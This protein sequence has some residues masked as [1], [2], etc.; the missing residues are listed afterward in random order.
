MEVDLRNCEQT[1]G[2]SSIIDFTDLKVVK[3]NRTRGISGKAIY[4]VP[5]DESFLGESIIAIKQ[6]GEYRLLPF[7]LEKQALCRAIGKS[8]A[9]PDL[10]AASDF[11]NPAQC[12]FP[13]V[14]LSF[15]NLNSSE[16]K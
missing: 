15:K 16:S 6:G 3:L 7:H 1:K 9:Y 2:D 13:N 4:H 11:P 14:K 8:Y 5:L 10:V 12:P